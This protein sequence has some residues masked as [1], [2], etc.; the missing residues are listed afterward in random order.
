MHGLPT[1]WDPSGAA[2]RFLDPVTA[3]AWSPC[4]RSIAISRGSRP[5][6][7]EVLDSAT[8]VRLAS[9]E[10]LTGDLGTGTE[11]FFSPDG[12]LLTWYGFD[13]TEFGRMKLISWDLQTGALVSAMT[14][15]EDHPYSPITA[16]ACGT[17]FGILYCGPSG[18][19]INTFYPLSGTHIRSRPVVNGR[20]TDK[21]WTHG[22]CVRF[23]TKT[24]GSITVWE[25]GF[26]SAHTPTEVETL[27]IPD[28]GCKI[29]HYFLVHPTL[30]R[31]ALACEGRVRIWDT[32]DS[33]FLLDSAHVAWDKRMSFSPD[34]RFFA[35]NSIPPGGKIADIYLWKESHTGYVLHQKLTSNFGACRPLF[36]PNGESVLALCDCAIQLRHT[37]DSTA[38]LSTF[39]V[40]T[41]QSSG[42][43]FALGFSPDEALAAVGR[44]KD[45]TIT[46]V[47]L[48][49]GIPR[50]IIDTGMEVYCLGVTGSSIV[51]VDDRKIVTWNLP[52]GDH[53]PN[54]RVNITDSVRTVTVDDDP[55]SVGRSTSDVSMSP[56]L[57]RI[58]VA[59]T[60][61]HHGTPTYSYLR[62]YD[63]L[64]GQHLETV[65]VDRGHHFIPIPWFT[66]DGCEVCCMGRL[67]KVERWK[68]VEDRKPGVTELD[69]L[70]Y[71]TRR[72]DG[73]TLQC[74]R[75]YQ[76]MDDRWILSP[77]GKRLLWL[78]PQWRSDEWRRRWGRRF[79]ALLHSELPEAVILELE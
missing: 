79:L 21:I 74:S 15:Q 49:S 18:V 38:S 52:A 5:P 64:T 24:L 71:V 28:G 51:A 4:C 77:S 25:T 10:F 45:K 55:H 33:R 57:H 11:L 22:E 36:S 8:L 2:A 17:M 6:T 43:H 39:S 20:P 44:K 27:S 61:G 78:P 66:P 3:A 67:C 60:H 26:A 12:R 58:T 9:L 75:G 65:T 29:P 7:V 16:S 35:C 48:K 72:P 19:A 62:F 30:P 54:L 32:Q 46:V 76:I 14:T 56:N 69:Y 23:I 37:M 40:P 63:V 50:L 13:A 70:G 31:L 42:D 59:G 53:I 34:G 1:S 68:I 47:D 73:S 41:S